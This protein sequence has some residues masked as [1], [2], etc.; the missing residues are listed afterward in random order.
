M[1]K[2]EKLYDKT[3]MPVDIDLLNSLLEK[4][5]SIPIHDLNF[6]VQQEENYRI[7]M[8]CSRL[9]N[10]L[11]KQINSLEQTN[12]QNEKLRIDEE[13][14]F[15]KV[16]QD[17]INSGKNFN[18]D[19]HGGSTNPLTVQPGWYTFKSWNLLGTE[20]IH[21]A[22]Q[23]HRFYIGVASNDKYDFAN[24]LYSEFKRTNIPFYFK[25]ERS[26]ENRPDK[27]VIYTSTDLLGKTMNILETIENRRPDLMKNCISPSIIVGKV[28]DKIG[29]ASEFPSSGV[30]Y[31]QIICNSLA[32]AI[33]STIDEYI[34]RSLNQSIKKIY[35]EKIEEVQKQ[36]CI[37]E[38]NGKKKIAVE[39]L[40]KYVPDFKIKLLDA[41]R[42]NLA[43]ASLD[44]N[45]MCFS[46]EAKKEIEKQYSSLKNKK[47]D[48]FD[49]NI[50][51]QVITL[52]N[53]NA[54]TIDE[55]LKRNRVWSLVPLN[56]TVTLRTL[57]ISM[58]GTKF[59]ENVI[60]R[61]SQFNDIQEFF[62]AYGVIVD[63][64]NVKEKME[65]ELINQNLDSSQEVYEKNTHMSR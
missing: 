49:P 34:K 31:T 41:F 25:V 51:N 38:T 6:S 27:I 32:K 21:N 17:F 46:I 47:I 52:P 44:L 11:Y 60:K 55:Y 7:V 40:M 64:N 61:A 59:I 57:G 65:E 22:S 62:N 2:P 37:L 10:A 14:F 4:Y 53:G 12:V 15:S 20:K 13:R 36:G 35:D 19:L 23:L 18:P 29:Y 26:L 42:K 58:S 16:S 54:M 30:S 5:K 56:A 8:G 63:R 43:Q 50:L 39:V 28:T 3:K 45:N 33:E 1:I 24:E 9:S 48:I